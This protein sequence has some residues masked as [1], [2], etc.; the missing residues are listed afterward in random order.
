MIRSFIRLQQVNPGFSADRVLTLRLSPNFSRVSTPVQFRTLSDT[1]LR[2]VRSTTGVASAALASNFPFS[3]GGV[4]TGPGSTSFEI[5]GRPVSRG[6]LAPQVDPTVVG[7]DYFSTIRQPILVG[8]DFTEHDDANALLVAVINQTMARHR[9]PSENPVGRR[10]TFD[11]GQHWT[12]I[13]GV[14]GDVKEYGLD[15]EVKD[16]V[17][18]AFQNGFISSL[19]VRTAGDPA[20]LVSAVRAVLHDVD[21]QLAVDRVQTLERLQQDS[22]ASP[23]V[24]TILLGLFALLALIISAS[25]IA[26][27]MAL[28][29]TQRTNELG[30]RMA[31]GASRESILMMVVRHGLALALTGTIAGIIG[32]I[33][34]TRLLSTLLYG[35]SPTEISTFAGVSVVFLAVAGVACLIPARAVTAIDPVIALRQD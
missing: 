12:T 23:R 24:T 8:R 4:A 11:Q 33:A 28:S 10:I 25:G 19:V 29:V 15:R 16:E 34:L 14:V 18:Q 1:I 30:I 26:A 13:V 2:R 27:V 32:A 9:W 20:A 6:E 22:V 17:Y 35:T 21:S 31:L 5:E 7:T 3:I